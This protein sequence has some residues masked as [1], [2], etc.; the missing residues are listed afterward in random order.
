[1][2]LV[3]SG[4]AKLATERL[5][6]GRTAVALHAG[7][8]DRR[9]WAPLAAQLDGRLGVVAYD[10]RGFGETTYDPE[11]FRHA[12]D[13]LAVLDAVAPGEPVWLLGASQG[14]RIAIDVA[15]AHPERVAGL[16]LLA[17]A[18]TG[19][20]E[21]ELELPPEVQA[22]S[23]AI[24]AAYDAED[25]DELNR[26]EARLWLDGPSAADG[27]VGDQPRR[28]FLDMN[29]IA[30][31]AP[32]PGE[33][34]DPPGAPALGRL[35]ELQPPALVVLGDLDLPHVLA[36]GRRIAGE[37]PR[38]QLTTVPNTAHLPH[39]ERPTQVAAAIGVFVAAV[40]G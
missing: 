20:D 21:E 37:A 25:L 5:S 8:A 40:G 30:L 38:A 12:D 13:L 35:A 4:A 23:D 10:R 19:L 6:C 3:A 29:G 18:I 17:S 32:D 34:L 22:L 28:L 26:L 7:V 36:V 14:G 33:E 2:D 16:V 39:L 15:L 11:P 24:D 31:R 27:R 9:S 1:M